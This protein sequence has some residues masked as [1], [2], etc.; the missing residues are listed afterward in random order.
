MVDW[1][2]PLIIFA[3]KDNIWEQEKDFPQIFC[4]FSTR[5]HGTMT[6]AH[7]WLKGQCT[8]GIYFVCKLIEM[9]NCA[10]INHQFTK[11]AIFGSCNGFDAVIKWMMEMQSVDKSQDKKVKRPHELYTEKHKIIKS[12]RKKIANHK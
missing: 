2:W 5:G 12:K 9:I 10:M 6:F 3:E 11:E 7:F 8:E 1:C 4:S